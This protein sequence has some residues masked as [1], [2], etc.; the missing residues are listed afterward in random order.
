MTCQLTTYYINQIFLLL[1]L[2]QL[3]S[4]CASTSYHTLPIRIQSFKFR[5][6]VCLVKSRA[7]NHVINQPF[8]QLPTQLILICQILICADQVLLTYPPH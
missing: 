7:K 2:E 1:F 5:S 6:F 3:K 4:K 8:G